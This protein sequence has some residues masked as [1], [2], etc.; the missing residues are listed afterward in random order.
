MQRTGR[1]VLKTLS[2]QFALPSRSLSLFQSFTNRSSVVPA[3]Y[4][5]YGGGAFGVF[6][7]HFHPKSKGLKTKQSAAKR[8]MKIGRG[9][10]GLKFAS[11][12]KSHLNAKKSRVRKRRLNT[13]KVL[14]G[15]MLKNMQAIICG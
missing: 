5:G 8:F 9:G 12:G 6:R 15:R 7:R 13:K 10:G 14:K 1:G 4:A 2:F 3:S 11:A